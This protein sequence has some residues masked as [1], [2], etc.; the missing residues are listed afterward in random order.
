MK[1]AINN[2][3]LRTV[4]PKLT[5]DTYATVESIA[6]HLSE[7]SAAS[8]LEGLLDGNWTQYISRT[9]V[10]INVL[11]SL[12]PLLIT[13]VGEENMYFTQETTG[14]RYFCKVAA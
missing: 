10:E 7:Y 12:G 6:N 2:D 13:E 8:Y 4:E 11:P 14:R 1:N 5:E 9:E 3:F